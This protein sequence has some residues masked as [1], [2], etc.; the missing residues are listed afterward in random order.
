[1]KEIIVNVPETIRFISDWVDIFNQINFNGHIIINKSVT[2]CGFTEY[3][4]NNNIPTILCSPRKVLLSNK[5]EQHLDSTY[6]VINTLEKVINADDAESNKDADQK[7]EDITYICNMKQGI[8][9]YINQ[10]VCNFSNPPKILVT[11]DSL[12]HVLEAINGSSLPINQFQVVVDEFQS[13]FIDASFKASTELNFVTNLQNVPNVCYLSATPM[14]KKYLEKIDEFKNL[15]YYQLKW[16]E[17]RLLSP[18]IQRKRVRA[19]STACLGIIE[20]YLNGCFPVKCLDGEKINESRE[21]VFYVNCVKEI[22]KII[23]TVNKKYPNS[24]NKNNVNIICSD[25]LGNRS[26]LKKIG[27][28]I[29]TV[30]LKGDPHKMFTFCTR[31]VYLGAD[32]YSTCAYTIICS[33]VNMS[34]LALDISLDLPQIMG[35]QR[36]EENVFRNEAILFYLYTSKIETREEL[37]KRMKTKKEITNTTLKSF[38]RMV[39]EDEKK[40]FTG[41][42][43]TKIFAA[44]YKDDYVGISEVTGEPTYNRLVEIQEERA[45]E[46]KNKEYG[47]E[48]QLFSSLINENFV[49]QEYKGDDSLKD[50]FLLEFKKETRFPERMK[51]YC[52]YCS[53]ANGNSTIINSQEIPVQYHTYY[54]FITPQKIKSLKYQESELSRV[55][56]DAL[57]S[58][59]LTLCIYGA[60][61]VGDRLSRVDIA[62]GLQNIYNQ[63]NIK[64]IAVATDLFEYFESKEAWLQDKITKKRSRG[65]ELLSK[66]KLL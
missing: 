60:F 52:E 27:F 30:P 53:K 28:S 39:N 65:F 64:K 17:S 12:K 6:L 1:M 25:T 5:H 23:T 11:Y 51:L 44:N 4:L 49:T 36:L 20:N 16:S 26:S 50:K 14:M 13:I 46:I 66:K 32:F 3:F 34:C 45:W 41:L 7:K 19:L 62:K 43:R 56:K 40:V 15:P 29:G 33:N 37:E 18:L 31:T 63:L 21:V 55:I 61:N 10:C 48:F 57:K 54:N 47:D 24:L 2:G 8:I 9:D 22:T 59:E 38:K 58:D 35:R 42:C